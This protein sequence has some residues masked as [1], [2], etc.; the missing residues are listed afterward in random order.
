MDASINLYLAFNEYK[1]TRRQRIVHYFVQAGVETDN[2]T[3]FTERINKDRSCDSYDG[4]CTFIGR[5][6]LQIR[7]KRNYALLGKSMGVDFVAKPDL[8]SGHEYFFKASAA[9]WD[10]KGLN[11]LADVGNMTTITETLLEG[12]PLQLK[13]RNMTLS[14]VEL[15]LPDSV[16]ISPQIPR[17]GFCY[18]TRKNDSL[19]VIGMRYGVYIS[20]IIENNVGVI[21]EDVDPHGPLPL[22]LVLYIPKCW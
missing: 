11:K 2:F 8:L 20:A 10:L 13:R 3:T 22:G 1:I 16:V 6:P 9:Y 21:D 12:M 18:K 17:C 19:Y 15:C 7:H 5:G 4:G 14:W